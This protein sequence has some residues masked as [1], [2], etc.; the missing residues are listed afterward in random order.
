MVI[1]DMKRVSIPGGAGNIEAAL[2]LVEA[3][4]TG[5]VVCHPHP[6]YGGSMYDGVVDHLCDGLTAAGAS[7][8]RFNFRGVGE[9]AGSF[10]QGHGEAED[11]LAVSDWFRAGYS[12]DALFLA[13]YSFGAGIALRAAPQT[14][15]QGLVLVAPPIAMFEDLQ[16][17]DTRAMIILGRRDQ[18][19]DCSMA[20]DFFAGYPNVRIEIIED[21]DH[22]F[23]SAG[24]QIAGLATEFIS[25][26]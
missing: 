9:S 8:L 20:C 1:R 17:D 4:S 19:V 6:L 21:A 25:G 11:V 22:F 3:S 14:A 26:A 18:I 24:D 5:A 10:D 7:S 15:S 23:V 12:L 16:P 13:G 2:E